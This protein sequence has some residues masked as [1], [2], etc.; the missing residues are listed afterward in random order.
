VRN[1]LTGNP[2][3]KIPVEECRHRWKNNIQIDL[4]EIGC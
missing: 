3:G 4:K 2:E 1:I